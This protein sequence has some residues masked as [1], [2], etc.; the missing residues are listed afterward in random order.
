MRVK[1]LTL[2]GEVSRRGDSMIFDSN[3]DN[4][5]DPLSQFRE[6]RYQPSKRCEVQGQC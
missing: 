2:I 3:F 6:L 4:V 1:I 5:G